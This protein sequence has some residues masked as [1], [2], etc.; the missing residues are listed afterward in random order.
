MKSI[1]C[2]IKHFAWSITDFYFCRG[3]TWPQNMFDTQNPVEN[4]KWKGENHKAQQSHAVLSSLPKKTKMW[5]HTTDALLQ[6]FLVSHLA[7]WDPFSRRWHTQQ[8]CRNHS[9]CVGAKGTAAVTGT[10]FSFC[11]R[12]TQIQHLQ[13]WFMFLSENHKKCLFP[14]LIH[15]KMAAEK[16]IVSMRDKGLQC[17]L[18][19]QKSLRF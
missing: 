18:R 2:P 4:G 3:Q 8:E 17:N 19:K 15:I 16:Y 10:T 11:S 9:S 12:S 1:F 5:S 14:P 7:S 13:N 6:L